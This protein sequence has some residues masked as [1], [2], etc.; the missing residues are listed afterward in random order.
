[1]QQ[2]SPREADNSTPPAAFPTQFDAKAQQRVPIKVE[3]DGEHYVVE[4]VFGSYENKDLMAEYA[5]RCKTKLRSGE[6]KGAVERESDSFEA[7]VW[8]WNKL[9]D[10]IEG[11]GDEGEELP[12]D[13]KDRVEDEDK[14]YAIRQL[15]ATE[16]I[17]LDTV[18]KSSG[19]R[20]PWGYKKTS[21][22]IRLRVRF[23]AYQIDTEHYLKT[24]DPKQS[25]RFHKLM[26]RAQHV[27]GSRLSQP[28][29]MLPS[30]ARDLAKL[31]NEL[32]E[33]VTGYVDDIVPLNHEVDV[34]IHH[35]S[36]GQESVIKN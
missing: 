3:Y 28:D 32:K 34:V 13:W 10:S 11:M 23:G 14:D 1:M 33:S 17:P 24:P 12:D 7:N 2:T 20:L 5:S 8:L 36:G 18:A 35:M 22:L 25:S 6:V 15:L 9:S 30:R 21:S 27:P 31:Y 16:I 26:S 4:H 29:T 19:K